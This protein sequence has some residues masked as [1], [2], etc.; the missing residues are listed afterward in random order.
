MGIEALVVAS[1][2]GSTAIGAA[3][4]FAGE[5]AARASKNLNDQR[6]AELDAENKRAADEAA[7]QA[8]T[9]SVFG[10][11]EDTAKALTTGFGFG[12]APNN[13]ANGRAQI[14]GTG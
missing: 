3:N 1:L 8:K 9:G 2:A 6:A 5:S 13:S 10:F 7:L 4:Y 12:N 11:N 14:T